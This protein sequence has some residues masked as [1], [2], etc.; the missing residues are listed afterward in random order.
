MIA[1]LPHLH[2]ISGQTSDFRSTTLITNANFW[3][4]C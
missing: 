1:P 3:F 2:E 4:C